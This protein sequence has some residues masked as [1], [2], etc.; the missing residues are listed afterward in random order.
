MSS[1]ENFGMPTAGTRI[2]H[3]IM[4]Y[5]FRLRFTDKNGQ[6]LPFGEGLT[7][8]VVSFSGHT[9]S[10]NYVRNGSFCAIFED[11]ITN[12]C[13]KGAQELIKMDDFSVHLDVLDGAEGVI[14]TTEFKNVKLEGV[15]HSH[16]DYAGGQNSNKAVFNCSIP[17]KVGSLVDA[18]T[19]NPV[20]DV[21]WTALS[22]SNFS[23]H[24]G[25]E[26]QLSS[27]VQIEMYFSF[28]DYAMT[29]N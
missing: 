5:R 26:K 28:D 20:A 17:S 2:L 13:M 6:S 19:E 18:I 10:R 21:V 29:F 9:Q 4:T 14:R 8:Q 11:D 25:P 3:P 23:I 27:I 1:I 16:F 22:G 7:K 15:T 24:V 12:I